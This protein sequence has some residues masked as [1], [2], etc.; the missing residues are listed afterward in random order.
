[1][2][3][4]SKKSVPVFDK[5][6]KQKGRA[7][8]GRAAAAAATAECRREMAEKLSSGE[9]EAQLAVVFRRAEERQQ[10]SSIV[11]I[12]GRGKRSNNFA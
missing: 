2:T 5:N 12:W 7:L 4:G 3:L 11:G 10:R 9:L 1:M 8:L 6:G